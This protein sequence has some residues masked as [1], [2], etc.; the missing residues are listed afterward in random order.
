MKIAP[1][2]I[3]PISNTYI[4]NNINLS[5]KKS[6]DCDSFEYSKHCYMESAPVVI[7][8]ER[9][10]QL[11]DFAKKYNLKFNDLSLLNQAFVYN[12]GDPHHIIAHADTYQR[13]ECI[14]D[15]VL[16]LCIL[17][18]LSENKKYY[19]E[20]S[21]SYAKS[22]IASNENIS[23]FGKKIGLDEMTYMPHRI[24]SH[25]AEQKRTA[26]MF[27]ALLGAMFLDGGDKGFENAYQFLKNNFESE[28]LNFKALEGHIEEKLAIYLDEHGYD[29]T[30]L[31]YSCISTDTQNAAIQNPRCIVEYDGKIIV[32]YQSNKTSKIVPKALNK[33]YER[34]IKEGVQILD[35]PQYDFFYIL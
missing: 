15:S 23:K 29:P 30:K 27:E 1:V 21:L 28:I 18:M 17:K 7:S 6:M 20:G 4:K 12:L 35:N 5:F 2:F 24:S 8:P 14:G 13:L 3:K 26:D 16:G 31:K 34:I 11:E 33:A 32:D 9:R 25:P 10:K 22:K 19:Q